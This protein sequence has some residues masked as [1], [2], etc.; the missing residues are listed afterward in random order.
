MAGA[1]RQRGRTAKLRERSGADEFHASARRLRRS[2]V[3]HRTGLLPGLEP[4]W[5]ATD[6]AEVRALRAAL[7]ENASS[8]TAAYESPRLVLK[9]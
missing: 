5:M 4:D 2:P 9:R 7:D 8:L 3:T 6:E 1:K